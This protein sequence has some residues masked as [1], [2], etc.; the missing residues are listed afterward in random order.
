MTTMEAMTTTTMKAMTTVVP[1]CR[2]F[3]RLPP[4]PSHLNGP[5]RRRATSSSGVAS[6]DPPPY[7][8]SWVRRATPGAAAGHT[9]IG[10]YPC[11]PE[12]LSRLL[13]LYQSIA[14]DVVTADPD[15]LGT[16][17]VSWQLCPDAEK[18]RVVS[19]SNWTS[20]EACRR[21]MT[22]KPFLQA[23]DKAKTEFVPLLSAPPE[24]LD[25]PVAYST[26]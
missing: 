21:V 17:L 19:V 24:Y 3:A 6:I 7:D 20:W 13:E 12:N 22:S 8:T 1:G 2:L 4:I 14:V 18:S 26:H 5:C 25:L 15:G 11:A 16:A 10:I 23:I 9:T